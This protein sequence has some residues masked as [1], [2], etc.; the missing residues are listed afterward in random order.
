MQKNI[1]SVYL[2]VYNKKILKNKDISKQKTFQRT[3]FII[4][5]IGKVFELIFKRR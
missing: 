4:K 1:A 5:Y 3:L 2:E